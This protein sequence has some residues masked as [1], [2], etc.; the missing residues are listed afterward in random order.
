MIVIFGHQNRF[1][2]NAADIAPEEVSVAVKEIL[3]Q[4]IS[5]SK[6]DLVKETSQL[7]G[8]GRLG[9]IV[10]ASMLRGIDTAIKRGFAKN[11]GD[12]I[13]ISD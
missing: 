10:E 8:F 2:Q 6:E 12:R 5:L 7:F 3:E 9:T 1:L 11:D 13:V 4:Q